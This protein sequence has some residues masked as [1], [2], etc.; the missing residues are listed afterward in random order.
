MSTVEEHILSLGFYCLHILRL[1]YTF[2]VKT[3]SLYKNNDL[4]GQ[5]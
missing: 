2:S 1:I 4:L 5:V 3:H